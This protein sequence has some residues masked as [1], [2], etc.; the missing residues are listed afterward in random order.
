[1]K[2]VEYKSP[3]KACFHTHSDS[4]CN[5]QVEK[6]GIIRLKPYNNNLWNSPHSH[7]HGQNI[8][9]VYP[10]PYVN[11]AE[12]SFIY[13]QELDCGCMF[14]VPSANLEFLEWKYDESK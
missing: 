1:M 10:V 4:V 6:Q 8:E 11:S 3:C 14:Y 9:D 7:M 5:W 13:K 12:E 2:S